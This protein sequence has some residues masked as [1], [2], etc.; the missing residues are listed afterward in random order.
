MWLGVGTLENPE[1]SL[2]MFRTENAQELTNLKAVLGVVG[3]LT[4]VDPTSKS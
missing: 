4:L 1:V 2:V 3:W